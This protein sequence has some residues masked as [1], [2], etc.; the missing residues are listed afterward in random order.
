MNV[1]V[2]GPRSLFNQT[3][4]ICGICG[5]YNGDPSN[6]F[7][8]CGEPPELPFEEFLLSNRFVITIGVMR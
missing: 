8:P 3:G 4:H 6:D 2:D 5:D 7:A 1:Y